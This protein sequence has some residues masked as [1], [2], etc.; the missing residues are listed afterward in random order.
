MKRSKIKFND[1]LNYELVCEVYKEIKSKTKNKRII[2]EY[3]VFLKS[4]LYRVLYDLY[5]NN[6][7][8]N[9][10]NI[11]LIKEPK[12]RIIMSQNIYDKIIN[13]IVAR[14]FLLP[15]LEKCLID[16]NVATRKGKGASYAFETIKK[17][18]NEFDKS[19]K[20]YCMKLDISKYFYNI[21]HKIL[22]ELIERRIKDKR[23]I[24]LI[25]NI[26]NTTNEEYV[27]ECITKLINNALI[28]CN[29]KNDIS[30]LKKI[31]LY[32]KGKGLCIGS[33][34]SQILAV[35][36]LNDVDHYIK[37]ELKYK[38]YVRYMDD[39]VL[40]SYDKDKLKNDYYLIEKKINE[41]KLSL[42]SKSRIYDCNNG[43][44][45]IGYRFIIRNNRAI[46]KYNKK[47][48][49]RVINNLKYSKKNNYKK[50]VLIRGSY[51]G[52]L[53]KTN[54]R[55]KKIYRN[56]NIINSAE[57]NKK[58]NEYYSGYIIFNKIG[59]SYIVS[60]DSA[61]MISNI[62]N[63]KYKRNRYVYSDKKFLYIKDSLRNMKINFV[64]ISGNSFCEEIMKY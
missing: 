62:L 39:L 21:D 23:I 8:F 3:E 6:I 9:R 14:N 52:Y 41:L 43:F 56:F 12:Y 15:S 7:H 4:N 24:N 30:E 37:E 32:K 61:Y 18:F 17:Y 36:Y 28:K 55:Y 47:T 33:M 10:Y 54:T 49:K 27:N 53:I 60:G 57:K 63:Y 34:T 5:T 16:T 64:I 11:F 38:Y 46:I 25:K 59:N 13:H 19:K 42:N 51:K 50:Y 31:P 45:F 29:N 48:I 58:L 2:F 44:N 22:L 35:Y 26:L 40:F 1:I 20:I